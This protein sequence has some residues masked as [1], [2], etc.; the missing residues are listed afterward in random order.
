MR[1][2]IS[3]NS[4]MREI[5]RRMCNKPGLHDDKSGYGL[6]NPGQVFDEGDEYFRNLV[7][8]ITED[9]YAIVVRKMSSVALPAG[10]GGRRP[11]LM[12]QSSIQ[13]EDDELI[14]EG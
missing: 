9:Y 10:V 4:V 11:R 12:S 5:L 7:S 13:L 6:L 14:E 3:N 8:E 2:A 1:Q